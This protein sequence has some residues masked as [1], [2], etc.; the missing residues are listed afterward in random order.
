[1]T[2]PFEAAKAAVEDRPVVGTFEYDGETYEVVR[3]PNA[4]LLAELTRLDSDDP[5]ALGM[6]VEFFHCTIGKDAYKRLRTAFFAKEFDS[7]EASVEALALVVQDVVEAST[8]R[9]TS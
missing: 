1:M 2:T 7:V 5:E 4:L 3:R 9:P 8:G 6:L